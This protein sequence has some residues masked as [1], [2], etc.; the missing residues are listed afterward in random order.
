MVKDLDIDGLNCSLHS[1]G[2]GSNLVI[3]L[4]GLKGSKDGKH[5]R[6]FA[7]FMYDLGYSVLRFNFSVGSA[8]DEREEFG[9]FLNTQVEELGRI[10]SYVN[11]NL[12]P[13]RTGIMGGCTGG[14]VALLAA[15]DERFEGAIDSVVTLAPY[16]I[17]RDK[18]QFDKKVRFEVF[19]ATVHDLLVE[20]KR[21]RGLQK[22]RLVYGLDSIRELF[23]VDM[24]YRVGKIPKDLPVRF[25]VGHKDPLVTREMVEPLFYAKS[26][27]KDLCV[28][29]S[30]SHGYANPREVR[31]VNGL[32]SGW[33]N[34]T[35]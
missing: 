18:M 5:R 17:P 3:L 8:L 24:V 35:L 10:L 9:R 12:R 1:R 27:I 4:H 20:T 26:G 29:Y 6:G 28:I 7:E 13:E 16:D 34:A 22:V 11:S 32:A 33:F 19:S 30:R 21:A 15:S 31:A 14:N 2:E 23:E 25:I